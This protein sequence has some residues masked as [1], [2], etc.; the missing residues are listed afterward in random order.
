M[1]EVRTVFFS[2]IDSPFGLPHLFELLDAP[3]CEV[4]AVVVGPGPSQTGGRMTVLD[5]WGRAVPRDLIAATA[6]SD[7]TL[8]RPARL[9]DA[10]LLD[11]LRGLSPDLIVSAGCWR[12]LPDDLLAVPRVAAV[13]LHPSPLPRVR[14]CDPWFWVLATGEPETAA[15][16]HHMIDRVDAG[17]IA[18][19]T[20]VPIEPDDTASSLRHKTTVESLRLIPRIIEAAAAGRLP[21]TPQEPDGA[22]PFRNAT[23]RDRTLDWS[24]PVEDVY[25]L[26]RASLD[27]PGAI[28]RFRGH[29]VRVLGAELG[30][31]ATLSTVEAPPGTILK[32]TPGTVIVAAGTGHVVLRRLG[33]DGQAMAAS[34]VV[35]RVPP[36]GAE[37]RFS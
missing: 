32:V 37:D 23:D 28:T 12:I 18:F 9:S 8:L 16:A 14:G 22:K 36:G 13:N 26:I 3:A 5:R 2:E 19:Q 24:H 34:S 29:V 21:R 10:A 25:R 33:V 35:E 20:T 30:T 11:E 31:D 17:D 4:V 6:A 7:I 1:Y 27:T 15:T